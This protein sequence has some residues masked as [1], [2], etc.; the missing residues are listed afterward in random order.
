MGGGKKSY[1]KEIDISPS[2]SKPFLVDERSVLCCGS[3][4]QKVICKAIKLLPS[5][6]LLFSL[7]S[8]ISFEI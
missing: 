7:A 2:A 6:P 3:H 4:V 8:I 1:E 5:N